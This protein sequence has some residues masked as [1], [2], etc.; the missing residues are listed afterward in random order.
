M[1]ERSKG[2]KIGAISLFVCAM[3][4]LSYVLAT[5]G[6][7]GPAV[8]PAQPVAEQP[9]ANAPQEPVVV[10]ARVSEEAPPPQEAPAEQDEQ[11]ITP[12]QVKKARSF[13]D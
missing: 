13:M 6:E 9:T 1:V 12:E 2:F 7:E 8:V 11:V 3:G 5:S 4:L 10:N